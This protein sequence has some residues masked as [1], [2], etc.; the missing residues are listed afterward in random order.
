[1]SIGLNGPPFFSLSGFRSQMSRWLGPPRH[2]E[3]DAALVASCGPAAALA[4][5]RREELHRREAQGGGRQVAQE[6]A[7]GHLAGRDQRRS[8]TSV[9][10]SLG[11]GRARLRPAASRDGRARIGRAVDRASVNQ[12]E[13]VGVEQGPEQVLQHAGACR[14]TTSR[15]LPGLLQLAWRS[16]T[17]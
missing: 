16:G 14:G 11:L 4:S 10:G 12:D 7:A 6:V 15:I 13:L 1:M 8:M 17:G 9:I 3:Q 5:Q 2:P